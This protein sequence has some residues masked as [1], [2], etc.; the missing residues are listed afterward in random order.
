MNLTKVCLTTC[1]AL[2][3]FFLLSLTQ[4]RLS[5]Q[6]SGSLQVSNEKQPVKTSS[7]LDSILQALQ[8]DVGQV[9]AH[10]FGRA[11]SYASFSNSLVRMKDDGRVQ[12]Y[13]KLSKA[14]PAE[15]AALEAA[16]AAI[17]IVNKDLSVVQAWVP[18]NQLSYLEQLSLVQFVK[19]P[20]YAITRIGS[21]TTQGDAILKANL[22]RA[23]GV[24]GIGIKVGV[25]SD[26]LGGLGTAQGSGD[27]PANVSIVTF[28]GS[29]AEGTAMLEI[30]HDLAPDAQLGF[31]GPLTS[32]EMIRCVNDL[33]NVFKAHIIVDDLGFFGEPYFADGPVANAVAAVVAQGV[34]YTSSAGNQA[35]EHYEADYLLVNAGT[36]VFS[37][38]HNFGARAGGPNDAAMNFTLLAG[39][40]VTI[41]LQWNDPFGASTNDYDL[42]V[43][44]QS[45][46]IIKASQVIQNG[47]QD[48]IEAVQITNP[49]TT[50]A[51]FQIVISKFSG[52][53][54]RLEMF[55]LF[56]G[57]GQIQEYGIAAD[58]IFGHPAVP[59]VFAAAAIDA[60]DPGNDT[61]ETFSSRGPSTLHFP[62]F[63]VRQTPTIAA[64]DGV[65]VTGAGGFPSVFFGTSA[66]SPHVAGVAALLKSKSPGISATDLGNAL[67]DT[68]ID[69]GTPGQ[70]TTYGSGRIDTV[71]AAAVLPYSV[72]VTNTGSGSGT[73]TSNP[74]GINCGST[75]AASFAL[76]TSVMLTATAA[77]GSTFNGWGG[78][79]S[80]TGTCAVTTDAAVTASFSAPPPPSSGTNSGGGGCTLAPSDKVDVVF[81]SLLLISV[82]LWAWRRKQLQSSP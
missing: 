11:P 2:A 79:C 45:G 29:G 6:L 42:Y 10:N 58:S 67:K 18:V 51:T 34:F 63:T 54:K 61:A 28:A 72:T 81:P 13:L 46:I 59:G 33:A 15:V 50:P 48:P 41:I 56:R 64:I 55:T 77:S 52:A 43:L 25:I 4:D 19:A 9:A 65:M 80:G 49:G 62:T 75:C 74:S 70:D 26:G 21:K 66:A 69:L 3:L 7:K 8:R 60:A 36:G 82:G 44:N 37:T 5:A 27:L 68:A 73:V 78:A 23:Q 40:S 71:A 53:A 12:V 22:L 31:C 47:I 76:G 38:A 30:V 16:G 57:S 20:D 32:L 35:Q 24:T 39:G 14:E 1:F 17:E